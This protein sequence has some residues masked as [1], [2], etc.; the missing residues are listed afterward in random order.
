[1]QIGDLNRRIEVLEKRVTK[2]AYGGEEIEWIPVGRVWAKIEPGSGSEFLNAQQV[3]AENSTKITVRFYAGLTVMERI[4]YG[5]K[6]Y[7]IIG[8]ADEGTSHR[9]TVITAKE[10]ISDELQCKTKKGKNDS[11]RRKGNRSDLEGYGGCGVGCTI[12]QC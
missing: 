11:T 3:Q 6:L 7:E 2:D 12:K 9:W 8:I 5:E 1:M 4:R 10:L